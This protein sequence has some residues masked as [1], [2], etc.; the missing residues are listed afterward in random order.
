MS[1]RTSIPRLALGIALGL[2]L[3]FAGIALVSWLAWHQWGPSPSLGALLAPPTAPAA[4]PTAHT[5]PPSAGS[6]SLFEQYQ[7]NLHGQALREAEQAARAD[8]GNQSNPQC[9]FWLEHARN[10]PTDQN[11]ENVVRFCH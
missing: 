5:P 8:A 11:R 6:D 4:P 10:A 9:Q 2:W 3:G 7:Q 1:T